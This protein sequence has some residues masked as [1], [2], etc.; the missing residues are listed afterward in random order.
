VALDLL[1][2]TSTETKLA[3]HHT[4]GITNVYKFTSRSVY[5][6]TKV[7]N[8]KN[9]KKQVKSCNKIH[10]QPLEST[11]EETFP[12]NANFWPYAAPTHSTTNKA[13]SKAFAIPQKNI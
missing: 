4:S 6:Q 11:L 7:D 13:T 12:E 8:E 10:C 5:D 3:P 2:S 1:A 9:N